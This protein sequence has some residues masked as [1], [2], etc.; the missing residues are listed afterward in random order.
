MWA[1]TCRAPGVLVSWTLSSIPYLPRHIL[2]ALIGEMRL[3]RSSVLGSTKS[4][5]ERSWLVRQGKQ[6]LGPRAMVGVG[7][8]SGML[9]AV[10]ETSISVSPR[11]NG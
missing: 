8:G 6:G 2:L 1:L 11:G 10:D 3:P 4:E 7:V 5:M 9:L